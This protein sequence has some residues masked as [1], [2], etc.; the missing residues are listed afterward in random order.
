MSGK[1][2]QLETHLERINN[3]LDKF[4]KK[5]HLNLRNDY[6]GEGRRGWKLRFNR[7]KDF[8]CCKFFEDEEL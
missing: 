7:E 1:K 5:Y 8:K 2:D 3:G 6:V 4:T